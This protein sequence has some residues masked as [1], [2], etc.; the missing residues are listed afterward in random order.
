MRHFRRMSMK[1][2]FLVFAFVI[3]SAVISF[4]QNNFYFP[5]IVNGNAGGVWKTTILLTNPTPNGAPASGSRTFTQ[6]TG[7]TSLG[8]QAGQMIVTWL[9]LNGQYI[10]GG[11][12]SP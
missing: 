5:H 7:G 8:S 11:I 1:R 2:S 3:G 6:D 9:A 10:E 4:G 12:T